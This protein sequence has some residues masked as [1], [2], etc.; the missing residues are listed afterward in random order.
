MGLKRNHPTADPC[1]TL[2]VPILCNRDL[3][4][5]KNS[6]EVLRIYSK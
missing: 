6:R 1:L 4:V 3:F 2:P 5:E